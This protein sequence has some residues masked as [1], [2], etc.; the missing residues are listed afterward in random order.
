MK[1]SGKVLQVVPALAAAGV[2]LLAS[3]DSFACSRVL[4]AD[5]GQAVL[6]GRNLDWPDTFHGTDLWLLPRGI[7][8]DGLATGK[9]ISW[10]AKY[11]SIVAATYI[12]PGKGAVSDGMNEKGLVANLLWLADGD[13][14]VRNPKKPGLSVSLWTQYVLDNYATVAEAVKAIQN[15]PYQIDTL[16]IPAGGAVLKANLHLAL[17]DKT[18]DSAIIE[19]IA[20]KPVVHHDRNYTIMT[21]DPIFEKQLENLSQY[22]TFGGNKPLPGGISPEDRFVRASYYLKKL[23]KPATLRQAL[24]GMFSITRNVA[25]PFST[26]ADLKHPNSSAT[27]WSTVADLT[28]GAYYFESATSPYLIWARFDGFNLEKGASPMKLDLSGDK[29]QVGDVT[30][31]FVKAAQ[32]DFVAIPEPAAK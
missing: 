10:T 9:T 6:V 31:Q 15:P 30:G 23:P 19:Y 8:R 32:F 21:N 13:Y 18:G 7:K 12:A 11:A 29:D 1:F 26:V 27:Q 25:Q 24:A 20:G 22:E 2:I 28:N 14:G 16:L 4:Y 3:G 5:N 17:A